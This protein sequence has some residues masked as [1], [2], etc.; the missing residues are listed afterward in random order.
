MATPVFTRKASL[1]VKAQSAEG[2]AA[3][4]GA[5]DGI[6]VEV[7]SNPFKLTREAIETN[8]ARDTLNKSASIPGGLMVEISGAVL[9]R[10]SGTPGTVADWD[11]LMLMSGFTSSDTTAAVPVAAE[12]GTAGTTTTLTLGAT[13]AATAQLYRGMP[14]AL[15]VN[16]AAGAS[17]FITDY[18]AGKVATLTTLFGTALDNTTKYQVLKNVRYTSHSDVDTMDFYTADLY[19]DGMRVRLVDARA[20]IDSFDFTTGGVPRMTFTIMGISANPLVS[21]ASPPAA[22]ADATFDPPIFRSGVVTMNREVIAIDKLT[23]SPGTELVQFKDPN[24]T[25]G[26]GPATPTGR[27]WTFQIDPLESRTNTV[28]RLNAFQAGG[29]HLIH[30]HW[31]STP[32]NRLAVTILA[33]QKTQISPADSQGGLRNSISGECTG[34]DGEEFIFTV[35]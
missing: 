19:I 21:E 34:G 23:V 4:P 29:R 5:S 31:G 18:T 6:L 9:L 1:F 16:P 24:A 20:K 26:F 30:A 32:G 25:E 10:G 3:S 11:I 12:V 7:Q 14:L 8:E 22:L 28:A 15:T 17:T 27:K 33:A 13:A 2:T 35:W